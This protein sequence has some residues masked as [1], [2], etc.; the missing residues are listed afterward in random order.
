LKDQ[1]FSIGGIYRRE[2]NGLHF[3]VFFPPN[4]M[5]GLKISDGCLLPEILCSV[6]ARSV[7]LSIVVGR[8]NYIG[9]TSPKSEK[10]MRI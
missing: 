6:N 3:A 1:G 4:N 10:V 2:E 5:G 8:Y 9:M 7:N